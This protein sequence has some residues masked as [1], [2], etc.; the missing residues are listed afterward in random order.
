M[1]VPSLFA[2]LL[3]AS[4]SA[5]QAK[6]EAECPPWPVNPFPKGIRPGSATDKVQRILETHHPRWLEHCEL[7][8]M[9]GLSRGA[10]TWALRYLSEHGMT[11]SIPSVR[12]QSYRRY[13]FV[14]GQA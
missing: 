12:H 3:S 11:R 7:M 5:A 4:A 13:Q 6:A 10:V 8:R 1:T 14:R 9:T 2:Q